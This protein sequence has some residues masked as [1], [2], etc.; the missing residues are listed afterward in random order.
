MND[1]KGTTLFLVAHLPHPWPPK[2]GYLLYQGQHEAISVRI[3]VLNGGCLHI[4]ILPSTR[5]FLSQPINV[6]SDT[7][8]KVIL[9]IVHSDTGFQVQ[10]SGQK[11]LP[12]SDGVP[13][14]TLLPQ[15]SVARDLS[16]NEPNASSACQDWI[17]KRSAKFSKP[18]TPRPDRTLK[19]IQEQARDLSVS[20][21]RM[22]HLIEQVRLGRDFLLGTLAG[23]MRALIYWL[24]GKDD[25]HEALNNPLLLRM[26]NLAQ[27]PLPVF[28]VPDI[29]A[30]VDTSSFQY[31][32]ADV[33]RLTR[34]YSTD[35]VT[36]LQ[37]SLVTKI[38]RLGP[39]PGK[40]K[41]VR[42][43]IK[44]LANTMG[45]SHYDF[46][47][48]DFIEVLRKMETEQGDQ[49]STLMCQTADTLVSLSEWVLSELKMRNIIG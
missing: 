46:D 19:T 26:A 32:K 30:V 27:L 1:D 22:R 44:E 41:N 23:E 10:I 4:T 14:I 2:N 35:Q 6:N 34:L 9:T 20:I 7:Q 12:Y 42:D 21:Q 3:V 33:P 49:V 39:S 24:D 47:Q 28:R 31:T 18:P 38:V 11:L 37:E 48:S 45:A 17:Q 43:L 40:T 16:L 25:Q 29:P 8:R 36:D 5:S 13:S 15:S